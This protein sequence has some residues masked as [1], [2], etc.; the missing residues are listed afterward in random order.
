M[1]R[2]STR[3][4]ILAQ[5]ARYPRLRPADLIKGLHQSTFGCGHLIRD[6][7][8]A[9]EFIRREAEG[10][11][12]PNGPVVEAL[13][14]GFVRFHLWGLRQYGMSPE[15]LAARFAASAKVRCGSTGEIEARLGVLLDLAAA[16]AL[17][18]SGEDA[19]AA[20]ADWRA[21]G[22]P[23]CHHSEQ[24]RTAYTPAYRVLWREQLSIDLREEMGEKTAPP[25]G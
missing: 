18:F 20:V 7:A 9:A 21:N 16:G 5:C 1:E 13:D 3:Q 4:F 8:A 6:R 2:E 11:A 19:E 25:E 17:P 14:G 10:C 22:Y 15:E 24:F 23:A 12:A